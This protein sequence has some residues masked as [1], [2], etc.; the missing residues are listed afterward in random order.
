ML[1]HDAPVLPDEPDEQYGSN[2]CMVPRDT[3]Q[4]IKE[5]ADGEFEVEF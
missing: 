1:R 4:L 2:G 5:L 3:S